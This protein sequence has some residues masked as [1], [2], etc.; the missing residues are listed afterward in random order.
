M[1]QAP[2]AFCAEKTLGKL[3]RWLRLMGFD[4]ILGPGG[5]A[6]G[7]RFFLTRTRA[8]RDRYPS[9][10]L[11]FIRANDPFD[12]LSQVIGR[13]DI[14]RNDVALFSRC[15]DCNQKLVPVAH[16]WVYNRVPDYVWQTQSQFQTCPQCHR[17]F[18]PGT[19]GR[20]ARAV[21]DTLF[22]RKEA[23]QC[24]GP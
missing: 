16:A 10:S 19:H 9:D 20:R 8:N 11:I 15:L 6:S 22:A 5:P 1:T 3:A 7:G 12:Q 24:Q 21:L 13:L 14:Q 2:I 17:I 4:T 18:W 23:T